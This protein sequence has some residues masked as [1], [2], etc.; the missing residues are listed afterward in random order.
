MGRFFNLTAGSGTKH[1]ILNDICDLN[2]HA[3]DLLVTLDQSFAFFRVT[4]LGA[5]LTLIFIFWHLL[6]QLL[7][8]HLSC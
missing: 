4:V 6:R 5:R 1:A 8:L 3:I 2:F 7:D